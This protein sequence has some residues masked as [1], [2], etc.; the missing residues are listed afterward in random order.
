MADEIDLAS[1]REEIARRSS[2]ITSRKPEGPQPTGRCLEC[3][4]VVA[5]YVRWCCAACRDDW[6]VTNKRFQRRLH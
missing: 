5:D 4:E 3:D 1:D 6:E 2:L